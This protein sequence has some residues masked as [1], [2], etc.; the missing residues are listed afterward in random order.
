MVG[1]GSGDCSN[2]VAGSCGNGGTTDLVHGSNKGEEVKRILESEES[3]L[4]EISFGLQRKLT[5]E[6]TSKG[7]Y[8]NGQED[9]YNEGIAAE[10]SEHNSRSPYHRS[11]LAISFEFRPNTLGPI[12]LFKPLNIPTQLQTNPNQFL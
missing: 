7:K 10:I 5:L 1:Y 4:T 12:S 3:S 9:Y 8:A 2:D 6:C 11:Y